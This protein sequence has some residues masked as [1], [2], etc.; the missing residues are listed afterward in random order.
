V[1]KL[2]LKEIKEIERMRKIE[3]CKKGIC[4]WCV[5]IRGLKNY[6]GE[7][8]VPIGMRDKKKAIAAWCP[9][10]EKFIKVLNVG[11]YFRKT[12]ERLPECVA[13]CK[14]KEKENHE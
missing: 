7:W 13:A 3:S 8:R 4:G 10:F 6:K 2:A 5:E 14:K 1:K 11:E 12:V 9:F